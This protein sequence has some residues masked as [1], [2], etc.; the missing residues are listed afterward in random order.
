[1]LPTVSDVIW[2]EAKASGLKHRS[3]MKDLRKRE[4]RR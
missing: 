4:I 2:G 1:M 3:A